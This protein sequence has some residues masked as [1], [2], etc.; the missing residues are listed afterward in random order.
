[1]A[2][3]SCRCRLHCAHLLKIVHS[4]LTASRLCRSRGARKKLVLVPT[5]GALHEGHLALVRRARKLAGKQGMVVVSI[6]V[7]PTQFGPKEDF[8]KYPRPFARDAELC[9][10][11]GVDLL[12]N[13]TP[14]QMYPSGFSTYVN[15]N[16]L[17]DALCGK[18]RPGHFR[19]VCT[20]VAKLFHI[21]SPDVSVFGKKDF[22]QFAIIRRMVRDLDMSVKIDGVETVRE[23][24]GLALSSRN[25]YLTPEERARAPVIRRALLAG[26]K[27]IR[28]ARKIVTGMIQPVPGAKIDYIEV[29]DAATLQPLTP[30]SRVAVVAAAVFI[31]KTRLIDNITLALKKPKS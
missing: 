18:S 15:E 28:S 29:L 16:S 7:N 11:A 13:P 19:G 8:S 2:T 9:R 3:G 30:E 23:R 27:N 26:S 17:G 12:F 1:M 6:F 21:L 22:Q 24:D 4:P 10:K 25:Q 5:M 31:G 14:E 20:V